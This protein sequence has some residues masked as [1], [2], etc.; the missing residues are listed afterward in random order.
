LPGDAYAKAFLS[1]YA[2]FLSLDAK[3]YVDEYT[4]RFGPRVHE[5]ALASS[6]PQRRRPGRLLAVR[7]GLFLVAAAAAAVLGLLAWQ[8][9]GGSS[10][11]ISRPAPVHPATRPTAPKAQQTPHPKPLPIPV[12]S[13]KAARGRCWIDA[14]LDSA[15]G[16]VVYIGTLAQGTTIRLSLRQPLWIRLGAPSTLD[17]SI[18]GKPVTDLPTQTASLIV[19]KTGIHAG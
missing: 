15:S 17:A 12:L 18:G 13:L 19:T 8:F 14:H 10:Q 3:L 4:A 16:R 5:P 9:G 2:D 6:P 11:P 7:P 1:S